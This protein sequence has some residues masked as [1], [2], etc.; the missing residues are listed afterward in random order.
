MADSYT[1]FSHQ[2]WFERIGGAIKGVLVGAVFFIVSFP[3]L[4]WNEGRAVHRAQALEEG[5]SS[6]VSVDS[7]SV[8]PGTEGR[9]VHF[10]GSATG[11]KLADPD[12]G[13]SREG[14]HLR[15][16]VEM[17][18]WKETK[19]SERRKD[20]IGGGEKTVTTYSY[21]PGWSEKL[22]RTEDF[23]G[24]GRSDG[25]HVN[26][27]EMRVP[28]QQWTAAKV[29]VG[30]FTLPRGLVD[31]IDE[32]QPVR[33]DDSMLANLSSEWKDAAT[34]QNGQFYLGRAGVRPDPS[35]PKIGDARV[36]FKL[37]P[38]GPVSV[39]ARQ[40]GSTLAPYQAKSG[41]LFILHSG[42]QTAAELISIEQQ[43]NTTLTWILRGVGFL[44]MWIGLA[45]ALNPLK[46]VADVV[47]FIGDLAGIGIVLITG[48]LAFALSLT[49]IA[50][51]WVAY[52]PVLGI[53]L[54]VI[55]AGGFVYAIQLRKK[56]AARRAA[57]FGQ[58]GMPMPPIPSRPPPQPLPPLPK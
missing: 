8:S 39:M 32:D 6:V 49:T 2:G 54:L 15:R 43:K 23:E 56:G 36:A 21:S 37:V 26:P 58:M 1:H 4:F 3:L 55:A 16:V 45:I 27:P 18:Q 25:Q 11:E 40:T 24:D 35:A 19:K 47:G 29:T 53:G 13:V 33:V 51:A 38:P 7:A 12:F 31:Q 9:L 34:V 57:S 5:A 14:I 48:V 52:R 42:T 20:G 28:A 17:Y 41:E 10:T 50:I 44:V 30:A 46:V 22:I